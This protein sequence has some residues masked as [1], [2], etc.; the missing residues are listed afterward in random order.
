VHL[1]LTSDIIVKTSDEI[2][3]LIANM[4]GKSCGL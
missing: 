2:A 4:R 1:G 3:E